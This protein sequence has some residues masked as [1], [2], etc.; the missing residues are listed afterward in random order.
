MQL[1]KP[2]S[3][4]SVPFGLGAGNSGAHLGPEAMMQVGMMRQ[5]AN[6]SLQ[7]RDEGA[8]TFDAEAVAGGFN[9]KLKHLNEVVALNRKLADRVS[10]VVEADRFPLILG[11]DHSIAIG[12]VTGLSHHY[13]NM[14]V[15]WIDAHADL[16]TEETSPTGNIHGMSLAVVLGRGA[17]AL[18][19]LTTGAALV[20]PENVVLVG[21]RQLDPGER[22]YIKAAGITCFTMH[23]IDR[24]GMAQVMDKAIATLAGKTDGVHLS[25][26]LDSLDPKEAPGTGT[27]VNGGIS[28]REAHF[29]LELLAESGLITSAEFV[30]VNPTR[31]TGNR[32]ARLA[33]ELI[34]SMFGQRIL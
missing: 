1:N 27:P 6:L 2:V 9:P 28:Y 7:V 20:K 3:V 4:I 30:E 13:A 21:T 26:D 5:L 16:N 25:F 18:T 10:S 15:I 17:K 11:G 24:M 8:V 22:A 29:A 14:G 23:D 34:C 31:D 19:D 12:T 33:V 32:T